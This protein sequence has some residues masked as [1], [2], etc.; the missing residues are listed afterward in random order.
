[1]FFKRLLRVILWLVEEVYADDLDSVCLCCHC[2]GGI[3]P[4][5]KGE[6]MFIVK[7]D[8]PAVGYS[9]SYSVTDSEGNAL[10]NEETTAEVTST[11]EAV[12]SVDSASGQ[13]SFGSP[14]VASVNVQVKDADNGN[15]LG[16]FGA[17]F[18]VTA[19]DP[20]AIAGGSIAF[21]GL[22][23]APAEPAPVEDQ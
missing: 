23:E 18:T 11:D 3:G 13:I 22:T 19:G 4:S 20:A 16:S 1:M 9:L 15:L 10:P 6:F 14:G 21:D 17:L 5:V 8:N 12:V 7:A 2:H